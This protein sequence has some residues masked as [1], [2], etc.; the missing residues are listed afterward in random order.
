[1]LL[2]H[3]EEARLIRYLIAEGLI[4][5]PEG[6][7]ARPDY[8]ERHVEGIRRYQAL[9]QDGVKPSQLKALLEAWRLP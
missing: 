8:G 9:R 4:P 1:M 7:H 6:S 3:V 5:G 2:I